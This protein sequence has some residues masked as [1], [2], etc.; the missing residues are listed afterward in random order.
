MQLKGG[1]IKCQRWRCV[2]PLENCKGWM[3]EDFS[4]SHSIGLSPRNSGRSARKARHTWKLQ[5]SNNFHVHVRRHCSRKERK[6][7]FLCC[8]FKDDQ[9]VGLKIQ[10]WTLGILG[11]RR[12]KQVCSRIYNQLWWQ[13]GS[14]CF[15]DGG[16]FR[17]F[18]TPSFPGDESAGRWCTEE[19]K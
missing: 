9:R 3:E 15:R 7:R 8:Y 14:S 16:R 5:W 17:E 18:R 1:M 11:M 19:E 10:R 4:R 13:M 6:W 12:R 2:T